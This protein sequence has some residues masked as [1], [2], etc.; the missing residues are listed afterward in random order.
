MRRTMRRLEEQ[1][2][3]RLI[4]RS[5]TCHQQRQE[6]RLRQ[7]ARKQA[8]MS[9]LCQSRGLKPLTARRLWLHMN[10]HEQP[11]RRRRMRR[12]AKKIKTKKMQ[13]MKK[14][15]RPQR[16]EAE[17]D[18]RPK[19]RRRQEVARSMGQRMQRKELVM[20]T[21]TKSQRVQ[22]EREVESKR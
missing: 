6:I 15:R 12:K 8:T 3:K 22:R 16:P 4:K 19:P 20:S 9:P 13:R 17:A 21:W 11:R 5:K 10:S 14:I 1:R 2:K 7:A 18:Q